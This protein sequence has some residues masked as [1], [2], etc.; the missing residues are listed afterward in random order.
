MTDLPE[1]TTFTPAERDAIYRVIHQR[2]N[3]LHGLRCDPI[4]AEI[5]TRILAAAHAAP[6]P[7]LSKPWDFIVVVSSAGRAALHQLVRRRQD[8]HRATLT[9]IRAA[10]YDGLRSEAIIDTPVTVAV[11]A[12]PTTGGHVNLGADDFGE[13]LIRS[14]S[15]AVENLWLAAQAEHIGVCVSGV[16]DPDEAARVLGVPAHMQVLLLLSLGYVDHVA[17]APSVAQAGWSRGRPLAWA[18]HQERYGQRGLPG[19]PAARIFDDTL[20]AIEPL[21]GGARDDQ[22]ARLV[23]LTGQPTPVLT[24]GLLVLFVAAGADPTAERSMPAVNAALARAHR[25]AEVA[26]AQVCAIDIAPTGAP[27]VP[28]ALHRPV[29]TTDE[30]LDPELIRAAVDTGISTAR[31]AFASGNCCLGAEIVATVP[32]QP[33]TAPIVAVPAGASPAQLYGLLAAANRPDLAALAGLVLGARALRLPIVL[34]GA[35]GAAAAAI[36]ASLHPG[37]L[38]ACFHAA[39]DPAGQVE[40][41]HTPTAAMSTEPGLTAAGIALL[42][43]LSR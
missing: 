23:A 14:V 16:F 12:D 39:R 11:T 15:C 35:T 18:V 7:A 4:P 17:T 27:P 43:Q 1:R 41:H 29:G 38:D 21:P 13:N 30:R 34:S 33:A 26:G 31:E 37:A 10:A 42:G 22:P 24:P 6:S 28:G 8:A 40:L 32:A 36:A 2:R 19:Q 25:A 20:A 9:P 5:L 3:I